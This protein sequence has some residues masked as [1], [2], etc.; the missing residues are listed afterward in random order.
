VSAFHD[1]Y[2]AHQRLLGIDEL[3]GISR[4]YRKDM[5]NAPEAHKEKDGEAK[6]KKAKK[7]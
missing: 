5:A 2:L 4:Q 7:E 3:P 1:Y 6:Q